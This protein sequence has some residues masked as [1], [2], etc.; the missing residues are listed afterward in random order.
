MSAKTFIIN[1]SV[2]HDDKSKDDIVVEMVRTAAQGLL[3]SAMLLQDK[4][5]P[6][7]SI[8]SDDLFEGV[9]SVPLMANEVTQEVT[10]EADPV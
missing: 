4:R 10:N 2:D 6:S 8:E 7:C 3:A 5:T 1:L 9:T